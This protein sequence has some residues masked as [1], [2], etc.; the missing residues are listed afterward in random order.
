MRAELAIAQQQAA[1]AN[2]D[3]TIARDQNKALEEEMAALRSTAEEEEEAPTP[4][5]SKILDRPNPFA[6]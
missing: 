6:P 2:R 5:R 4:K 1:S 3:L